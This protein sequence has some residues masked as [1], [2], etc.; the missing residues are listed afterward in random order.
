MIVSCHRHTRRGRSSGG[1]QSFREGRFIEC[2]GLEEFE[3]DFFKLDLVGILDGGFRA[4]GIHF[5][6]SNTRWSEW[7][8]AR[9]VNLDS[10][11]HE[12]VTEFYGFFRSAK[13]HSIIRLTASSCSAAVKGS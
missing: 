11:I 8:T 1:P 4:N 13:P 3:F 12:I 5:G 7:N 2:T 6:V 9:D 10:K